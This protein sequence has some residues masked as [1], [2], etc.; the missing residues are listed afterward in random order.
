MPDIAIAHTTTPFVSTYP[1][2]S[3]FGTKR[4][5]PGTIP[6]GNGLSVAFSPS[7][8]D[9]AISHLSTPRVSAYP[10]SSGF[11]TKY[12]NP[13]TLPAGTGRGV[14]FSPSSTTS[15]SLTSSIPKAIFAM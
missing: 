12:A 3:G 13:G 2:S 8:A 1:W 4:S 7:G 11:G 6:V 9:I 15:M 14:A 10:W 5:D